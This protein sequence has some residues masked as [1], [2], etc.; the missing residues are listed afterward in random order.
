MTASEQLVPLI[1]RADWT[2][3]S[4]SA[5]VVIRRNRTWATPTW[6]QAG[7][8]LLIGPGGR[9]RF[10]PIRGPR[11]SSAADQDEI[12][13]IVCDGQSCWVI[14]G[15][16]ADRYVA[17]PVRTPMD[18]VIRPSV[19]LSRLRLISRGVTELHGRSVHQVRGTPRMAG[20][21]PTDGGVLRDGADMLIDAELGLLLRLESV[22]AGK[23]RTIL[24]LRDLTV[25]PPESSDLANFRPAPGVDIEDELLGHGPAYFGT[26]PQ[27]HELDPGRDWSGD[28]EPAFHVG[29][30]T[31]RFVGWRLARPAPR[32]DVPA[33]DEATMPATEAEPDQGDPPSD[34]LL[35]L[36]ARSGLPP[37]NLGAQVHLWNDADVTRQGIG[38]AIFADREFRRSL[39]VGFFGR[40]NPMP[41]RRSFHRSALLRVAIPDRYRIEYRRDDRPRQPLTVGCDGHR[42]RKAYHNRVVGCPAEP[43]PP[44][45]VRLLDPAWLLDGWQLTVAGQAIVGGRQAVRVIARPLARRV[46]SAVADAQASMRIALLLDAELGIVLRQVSFVDGLPAVRFEL[47]DVTVHQGDLPGDFG[48]EVGPGI[49][50]I[51]SDGGP[52]H[53]LD[54]PAPVIAAAD[55]GTAVLSGMRSAVVRLSEELSKNRSAASGV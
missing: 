41:L 51:E 33:D 48:V 21:Q 14:R 37:V 19:L 47:R 15:A 7:Y 22:V 35:N 53:D 20:C 39:S 8:G 44:E 29:A 1:Y 50:V 45:F 34:E 24:E 28:D 2:A 38:A 52:L 10:E 3:W 54:L 17:D 26:E 23:P 11:S 27:A 25:D 32:R 46:L 43:L 36:I 31:V 42:L 40:W 6:T 4:V 30:A 49:P 5:N 12:S 16:E 9:Y 18:G 13:Q 55:A